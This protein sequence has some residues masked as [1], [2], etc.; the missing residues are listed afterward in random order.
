MRRWRKRK[1]SSPASCGRSGGSAVYARARPGCF[2][3]GAARA[4][5]PARHRDERSRPRSRP[6]EDSTLL[7]T[8][9]G[10]AG[11]EHCLQRRGNDHITVGLVGDRHH[12]VDEQRVAAGS[13][14][15]P[16]PEIAD[17]LLTD[18]SDDASSPGV[19]PEVTGHVG[20]SST[21]SG[22]AMQS[23]RSAIPSRGAQR[24]RQGQGTSPCPT[25]CRRPRRRAARARQRARASCERP[26]RSRRLT[27]VSSRSPRSERI[28]AAA[29]SSTGSRSSCFST[30][31]TGQYVI[32]S[33]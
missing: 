4:R 31:T 23:T 25:G 1:P 30:S 27:L 32:P 2:V 14:G 16:L 26:R 9:V 18:E 10:P 20:R 11:R 12:L 15:D 19:E 7:R 6:L 29:S 5:A 22:R 3:T 28:A 8:P 24:A 21:S 33:P 17:D 13:T